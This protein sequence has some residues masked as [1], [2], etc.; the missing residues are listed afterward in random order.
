MLY[1][2]VKFYICPNKAPLTVRHMG[3]LAGDLSD[4]GDPG[5]IQLISQFPGYPPLSQYELPKAAYLWKR[6]SFK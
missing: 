6:S 5:L 2:I 3:N 4:S 1:G